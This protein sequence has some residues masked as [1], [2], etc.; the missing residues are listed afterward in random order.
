MLVGRWVFRAVRPG[1]DA[2]LQVSLKGNDGPVPASRDACLSRET[3]RSTSLV[4]L[5]VAFL[6]QRPS[7]QLLRSF[8]PCATHHGCPTGRGECGDTVSAKDNW[9]RVES[10]CQLT[11]RAAQR[12]GDVHYFYGP[13]TAQPLHHRFNKGSYVYLFEN[14]NERRARIEVANA[15]GTED[16]DAFDGCEKTLYPAPS[17]RCLS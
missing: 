16:Q 9:F 15:V 12:F 13:E 1:G 3:R 10:C 17:T 2:G 11:T 5:V 14:A 7:H 8:T 4:S 6:R